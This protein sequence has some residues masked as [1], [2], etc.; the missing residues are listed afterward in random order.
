M[1]DRSAPRKTTLEIPFPSVK[2]YT[3]GS[4]PPPPRISLLPPHDSTAYIIDQFVLPSDKDL[5]P[6]SRRLLHYHIGFTDLPAVKT[7]VPCHK[8]LDYVSPRGL[9]EWE[10]KTLAG[11]E[12]E[13]ARMLAEKQRADHAKRK[14]GRPAKVPM[15]DVGLDVLSSQGQALLLAEQVSGPS[16]S[17]PQKRRL[18][19]VLDTEVGDTSNVDSDDAAIHWQ[20]QG[21]PESDDIVYE[22]EVEADSE[23]VDQLP[24]DYGE[25]PSR[26]SSLMQ[27]SQDA[28]RNSST[29]SPTKAGQFKS[30]SSDQMYTQSNGSTPG[31]IHPAWAHALGRQNQPPAQTP[32]ENGHATSRFRL[33]SRFST[34]D[35]EARSAK[36]SKRKDQFNGKGSLHDKQPKTKKQK[37]ERPPEPAPKVEE[38]WEVKDLLDD[39]WFAEKGVKVHRYLVLWEGTWPVGQ[40]PTWEPAE[41][42]QDEALLKR[43]QKRK[44]AGLLKPPKKQ[45][46][47]HQYLP[48]T[49]SSSVAEAFEAGIDEHI[50]PAGAGVESDAEVPDETFLVTENAG[51]ITANGR[52]PAPPP[53]VVRYN[54]GQVQPG[55][56]TGVN[57][58]QINKQ[59]VEAQTHPDPITMST[60]CSGSGLRASALHLHVPGPRA[61]HAGWID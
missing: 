17:E 26:A 49:K 9:E 1:A 59:G 14:A 36:A 12:E 7:L 57:G 33:S 22:D 39:Q 43:Y 15:E 55:L 25:T 34:P 32:R 48:G 19:R 5:N 52:R 4:G 31:R 56:L 35:M 46:T 58:E 29:G 51:D 61:E 3:P 47:L 21:E 6:D 2:R 13:R 53:R 40:N 42:V 27:P 54:A 16:L 44:A 23:S 45:K 11:K 38:E 28:S 50:G 20:L 8:V 24:M 10:Y 41:N 30:V 60:T 37:T 18:G